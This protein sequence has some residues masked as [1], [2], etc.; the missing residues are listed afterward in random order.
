MLWQKLYGFKICTTSRS[1]NSVLWG[2]GGVKQ[3]VRMLWLFSSS[4]TGDWTEFTFAKTFGAVTRDR[5]KNWPIADWRVSRNDPTNNCGTHFVS[6]SLFIFRSLSGDWVAC[7]QTLFYF[8]KSP[9]VYILSP[10]LDGLWRESKGSVSRLRIGDI[11]SVT[12]IC[13]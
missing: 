3:N 5:E 10:A 11:T 4:E 8:N 9:A 6:S 13:M 1:L 7:T 12:W 2:R